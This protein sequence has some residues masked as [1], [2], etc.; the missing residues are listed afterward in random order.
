MIRECK[1]C[2]TPFE[3]SASN[4]KKIFCKNS[5]RTLFS[6]RKNGITMPSW[7]SEKIT[8][9]KSTSINGLPNNEILGKKLVPITK[10][11]TKTKTIPNPE[12]LK[13]AGFITENRSMIAS[14]FKEKSSKITKFNRLLS[15]NQDVIGSIFGSVLGAIGGSMLGKTNNDKIAYGAIGGILFGLIGNAI[16]TQLKSDDE[17]KVVKELENIK[18]DI[19]KI[20]AAIN[21]FNVIADF[22]E[23]ESKKV[24]RTISQEYLDKYTEYIEVEEEISKNEVKIPIPIKV[25]V[26]ANNIKN[27]LIDLDKF[28]SIKFEVLEFSRESKYF[29]V[30]GNPQENF[31]AMIY[32]QAGNGKSTYAINLAEFL[33]KN[34]GRVLYNSSEEGV[35]LTLQNKVKN[36]SSD[37]FDISTCK[38]GGDFI[39]LLKSIDKKPRFIF[40]DSLNDMNLSL[41][42][43]KEI[44][45]LDTKRGIIWIMQNTKSGDF[46]GD[47]KFFHEADI[48]LKIENF[49]AKEEKGRYKIKQF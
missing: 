24:K 18:L 25:P 22:W 11:V 41:E 26:N 10:E 2:G 1:Y 46:K 29:D 19:S 28:K 14:L 5:C 16:G 40:L 23:V 44:I 17:K 9:K 48:V 30:I 3:V 42:E 45:S 39:K 7:L 21:E 33:A 8:L 6:Q 34:F 47:N 43:L 37:M 36:I 31:R 4:T 27:E 38:N 12:Y 49:L 20:D 13:I 32:G 15:H 35:S